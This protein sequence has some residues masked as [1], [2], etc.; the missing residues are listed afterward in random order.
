MFEQSS[1]SITFDRAAEYYDQ[2]RGFP[3]GV[4]QQVAVQFAESGRLDTNSHVLEIGIGTGRIA[5][6]LARHVGGI[7]GVDLSR[8]MMARMREKQT[9]EDVRLVEADATQFPF[10]SKMFDAAVA[11]HVFHLIPGWQEV[12]KELSRIL[13]SEGFLMVG[14]NEHTGSNPAFRS[15]QEAWKSAVPAKTQR[16]VGVPEE[17]SETFLTDMGWE[18]AGAQTVRFQFAQSPMDYFHRLE[19]RLYSASWLI[20]DDEHA[21]AMIALTRALEGNYPEPEVPITIDTGFEIRS[22]RPPQ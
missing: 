22:F 19:H 9:N 17:K 20:S 15:L 5:L 7:T 10:A 16:R 4:D 1:E 18:D 13:K 11:V 2:T 12:V 3:P 8:R 14:Q 21:Q 6:P